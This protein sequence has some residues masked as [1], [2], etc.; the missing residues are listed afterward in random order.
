MYDADVGF[1]YVG[2]QR[3]STLHVAIRI[4]EG[5]QSKNENSIRYIHLCYKV[6]I[7]YVIIRHQASSFNVVSIPQRPP[8]L[9]QSRTCPESL[10]ERQHFI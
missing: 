2:V 7:R 9:K 5:R 6:Y 10:S 4:L 8:C 1:P 3:E